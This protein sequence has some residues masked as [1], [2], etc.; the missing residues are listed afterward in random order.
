M[1]T[2]MLAAPIIENREAP[3]GAEIEVARRISS[4][5]ADAV[6]AIARIEGK[7]SDLD[8]AK[9]RGATLQTGGTSTNRAPSGGGGGGI[10]D[11]TNKLAEF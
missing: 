9:K 11:G 1:L 5:T 8:A 6:A 7:R 3:A 2:P 10:E 4:G